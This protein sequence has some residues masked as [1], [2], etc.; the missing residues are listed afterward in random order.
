MWI[1][2]SIFI[3]KMQGYFLV[4][5]YEIVHKRVYSHRVV[6]GRNLEGTVVQKWSDQSKYEGWFK[7]WRCTCFLPMIEMGLLPRFVVPCDC[8]DA[9]HWSCGDGLCNSGAC[10]SDW[11]HRDHDL[12]WSS[13]RNYPSCGTL[14]ECH[15]RC[16]YSWS[17]CEGRLLPV[18]PHHPTH[19]WQYSCSSG[20][21]VAHPAGSSIGDDCGLC[22]YS[23]GSPHWIQQGPAGK[24]NE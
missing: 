4:Q 13:G 15:S 9:C 23:L 19:L 18:T 16:D 24:Y 14:F 17:I 1:R 8:H 20:R 5:D 11:L 21:W 2:I 22:P 6:L 7:Q 10:W 12:V 3:Q